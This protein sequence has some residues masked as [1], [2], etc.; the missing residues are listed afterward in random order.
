MEEWKWEVDLNA[1][2]GPMASCSN[3]RP[4]CESDNATVQV[5]DGELVVRI[6]PPADWTLRIPLDI[7]KQLL[8][9]ARKE[10]R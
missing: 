3:T 5:Q 8:A 1:E 2:G 10:E 6:S 4:H 9:A 7:L